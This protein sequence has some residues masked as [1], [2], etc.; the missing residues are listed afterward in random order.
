[1]ADAQLRALGSSTDIKSMYILVF[2]RQMRALQPVLPK[3]IIT[4]ASD[5]GHT[6][7]S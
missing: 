5:N 1:M 4:A 3:N 2:P 6:D 7:A